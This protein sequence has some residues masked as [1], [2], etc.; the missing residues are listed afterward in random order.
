M[1]AKDW[2]YHHIGGPLTKWDY[3]YMVFIVLMTNLST[4]GW[5]IGSGVL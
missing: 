5:L 1:T 2:F 4:A 3:A